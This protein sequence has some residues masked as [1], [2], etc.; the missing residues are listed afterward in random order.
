MGK[1][2]GKSTQGRAQCEERRVE[3]VEKGP[4]SSAIADGDKSEVKERPGRDLH[5]ALTSG[6]GVGSATG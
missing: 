1:Y 2:E 4:I 6:L 3:W 5:H